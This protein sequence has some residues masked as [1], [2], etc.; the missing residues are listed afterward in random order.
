MTYFKGIDAPDTEPRRNQFCDPKRQSAF[1]EKVA[2]TVVDGDLYFSQRSPAHQ[3]FYVPVEKGEHGLEVDGLIC[4]THVFKKPFPDLDG[5]WHEYDGGGNLVIKIRSTD[6]GDLA[7]TALEAIES[8]LYRTPLGRAVGRDPLR[9]MA[10]SLLTAFGIERDDEFQS[11]FTVNTDAEAMAKN[12]LRELLLYAPET[13]YDEALG[14]LGAEYDNVGFADGSAEYTSLLNGRSN[15][16]GEARDG[17]PLP[18]LSQPVFYAVLGGKHEA[19]G[20]QGRI[21]ALMQAVGLDEEDL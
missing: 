13:G 6:D 14:N 8:A 19:R 16:F 11:R 1:T 3:R 10:K 18:L 2:K 17:S 7:Y 21:D 12:A 9:P 5:R 20:F 4:V 15:G